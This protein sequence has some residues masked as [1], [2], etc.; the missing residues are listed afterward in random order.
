MWVEVTSNLLAEAFRSQYVAPPPFIWLLLA[1]LWV[2]EGP[3]TS[4]WQN[5]KEGSPHPLRPNE[6][7]YGALVRNKPVLLF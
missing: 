3:S 6:E 1:D 5:D 2:V 4:L 7:K